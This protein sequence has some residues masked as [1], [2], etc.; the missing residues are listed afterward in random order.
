MRIV[1]LAGCTNRRRQGAQSPAKEPWEIGRLRMFGLLAF[2]TRGPTWAMNAGF[3]AP[4]SPSSLFRDDDI[5]TT[6]VL[7]EANACADACRSGRRPPP[8][9]KVVSCR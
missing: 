8:D 2:R 6:A 9:V 5:A 3:G 1:L 7:V 4:H